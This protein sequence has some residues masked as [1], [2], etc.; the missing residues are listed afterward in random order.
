VQR[1][2]AIPGYA[3]QISNP[4]PKEKM[5]QYAVEWQM[6]IVDMQGHNIKTSLNFDL[7]KSENTQSGQDSAP[8]KLNAYVADW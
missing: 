1:A 6:E 4:D 8:K 7:R 3:H 5:M 2:F